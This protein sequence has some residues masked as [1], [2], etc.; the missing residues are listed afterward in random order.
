[1][2]ASDSAVIV[3]V[4]EI[5]PMVKEF[6]GQLD[7]T[8]VWGVPAHV[9][10]LAPFLPADRIGPGELRTLIE[11]VRSVARFD[12]T[13]RRLEWFGED[14]LWLA[15]EPDDG[16]RALTTAVWSA[17]PDCLPYGGA[18]AELVPHLTVGAHAELNRMR[19]AAHATS[20]RLPV[21]AAVRAAH[22][23]QGHDAPGAW[24]TVAELPLG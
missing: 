19:D 15:P 14:V 17:F 11:A 12:V 21:K 16:F 18:F 4:S 20:A 13:F 3:P 1:M 22:L 5:E 8:A 23:Y 24:R 2:V 10:V 6:R 9:T 7:R